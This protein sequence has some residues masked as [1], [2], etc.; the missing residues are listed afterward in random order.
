[1]KG[2]DNRWQDPRGWEAFAVEWRRKEVTELT[3]WNA[4][5]ARGVARH[6]PPTRVLVWPALSQEPKPCCKK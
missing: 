1:M 5:V 4:K 6:Y 3:V 2:L